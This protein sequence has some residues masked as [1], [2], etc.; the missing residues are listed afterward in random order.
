MSVSTDGIICYGIYFGEDFKFP[1]YNDEY[2][3]D[4]EDWWIYEV[5]KYKSPIDIWDENGQLRNDVKISKE[6]YEL[7]YKSKREFV[8]EHPLPVQQVRTAADSYVEIILAVPGSKL[9]ASRGCP[10]IFNPKDLKVTEEQ[11]NK[12]VEFCKKYL[13]TSEEDIPKWYLASYWG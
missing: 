10:E 4:I 1:W 8:K 5:C 9:S 12:L 6:D 13:G 11:H 3:Y 7:Y 2:D